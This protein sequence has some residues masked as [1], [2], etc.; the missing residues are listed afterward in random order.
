MLFAPELVLLIGSLLIF[1]LSL[2]ERKGKGAERLTMLVGCLTVVVLLFSFKSEGT[3]FF[4]V[5]EIDF[6]S[7]LFKLLIVLGMLFVTGF[8]KD[9]KGIGENIKPEYFLFMVLSTLGLV[10]LVSSV[11]LLTLFIS[12][13]LSSYCLYLMVPMRDDR[14]GDRAQM[15]GAIKYILFGVVATGV[16][17]YG[18]SFLYGLTG[19]TYLEFLI[20]EVQNLM[21][22]PT[23]VLATAMVMGGFFF[24][25][26]IFPFHFWVPDVYQGASN[27]TTSF[28]G[29]VP[30]LAAV[31][32]LIRLTM[33]IS[34]S[35][36]GTMLTNMMM[37]LAIFSMFYGNLAAL[38]QKDIKRMLGFS[39]IA[40]AGFILVGLL[41]LKT[42]GMATS[43]YYIIGYVVMNLACF[44]VICQVSS[45]GENLLVA[46]FNGLHKRAPLLALTLLVGM[47]ALAGIPPFV[48]FMGKFML[49]VGALDEGYITLVILAA[50]NTAIALF[51]YLSVV[52]AAYCEAPE[53]HDKAAIPDGM[54][55]ALSVILMIVIIIMGVAPDKFM[56]LTTMAVNSLF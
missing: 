26:A 5:Y 11:E 21:G 24:K 30:K 9:L 1:F 13:E 17:L 14:H 33:F 8:T 10:M 28:I 36:G 25:L 18:M 19:T 2:G 42:T 39:G 41:T 6:F 34:P 45:K 49:L 27:P 53:N 7:Q 37:L 31:A 51:Y 22:Q 29:T 4:K 55:N 23:A 38:V 16:M 32:I 52:K 44:L 3:L 40:H 50:I 43:L 54:V 48:G 35:E 47:M 20:P 46:D 12:L 15:E 56:S